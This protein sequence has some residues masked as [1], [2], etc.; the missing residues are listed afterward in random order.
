MDPDRVL[1]GEVRGG[2]AL[3]MLL[4]MS[5][6]N[7]G[8]MCT[9]H[10]DAT[11]TVFPKLAAYVAMADMNLPV[12]TVNLL[13]ASAVHTPL[14]KSAPAKSVYIISPTKIAAAASASGL[15]MCCLLCGMHLRISGTQQQQQSS[16]RRL[17]RPRCSQLQRHR[18]RWSSIVERS[19][20]KG[21][22]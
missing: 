15:G 1:I 21:Q 4:A 17:L 6:G 10:A 8:S 12:D 18:H 14:P 7:N 13:V 19:T 22:P 20:W 11:S 5:Q 2:E 3:P 16:L 9:I